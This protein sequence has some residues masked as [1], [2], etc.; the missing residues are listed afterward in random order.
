VFDRI[1]LKYSSAESGIIYLHYEKIG[2]ICL[3]CGMMFHT[4]GNCY[5]RQQIITEKI[6]MGKLEEAQGVP[7]QRFGSWIIEP[8]EVPKNY[9]I[10]G[11]GSNPVF[12][13]FQNPHLSRFQRNFESPHGRKGTMNSPNQLL[14]IRDSQQRQILQLQESSSVVATK[15]KEGKGSAHCI[16]SSNQL[17]DGAFHRQ[18]GQ[19]K[20]TLR[21]PVEPLQTPHSYQTWQTPVTP[22]AQ[23]AMDPSAQIPHNTPI[24]PIQ[25]ISHPTGPIPTTLQAPISKSSPKRPAPSPEHYLGPQSKKPADF[26]PQDGQGHGADLSALPVATVGYPQET[27]QI[28]VTQM[29]LLGPCP[30]EAILEGEGARGGLVDDSQAGNGLLGPRPQQ[31]ATF[32]PGIS[33]NLPNARGGNRRRPSGWDVQETATSGNCN[34][35]V[36]GVTHYKPRSTTW[37][38]ICRS[39]EVDLGSPAS[40]NSGKAM[41]IPDVTGTS[42]VCPSPAGSSAHEGEEHDPW[43]LRTPSPNNSVDTQDSRLGVLSPPR[44][45]SEHYVGLDAVYGNYTAGNA[46]NVQG[47]DQLGTDS[48]S[49]TQVLRDDCRGENVDMDYEAAAPAFKA[50]RAQ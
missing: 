3:F 49:T 5:L 2:R 4:I 38:R 33:T 30:E 8:A 22:N 14:Q 20:N 35:S 9:A 23:S 12:S 41:G 6:Q 18:H 13:T 39:K 47:Q 21:H 46:S 50:P 26:M 40:R 37:H 29:P 43:P 11:E 24:P 44:M 45:V 10:S 34:R 31:G 27:H 19:N 48:S 1:K 25:E 28:S 7:F 36:Q 17:G 15:Q 32:C 16:Q 42:L